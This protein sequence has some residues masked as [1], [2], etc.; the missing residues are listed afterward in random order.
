MEFDFFLTGQTPSK[1]NTHEVRKRG[2]RYSIGLSDKY[3]EWEERAAEELAVQKYENDLDTLMNPVQLCAKITWLW[4]GRGNVPDLSNVIQSIEDAL[5]RARVIDNDRQIVSL[6]GSR[7]NII[8]SG[9][10]G[11]VIH[12]IECDKQ[13]RPI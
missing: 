7:L 9:E 4:S 11:V 6:D 8:T 1:K 3:R 13:G 2:V 10:P 12:L 5:Q